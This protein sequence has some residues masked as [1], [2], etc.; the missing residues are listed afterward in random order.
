M[1][2]VN[3]FLCL[4]YM[5]SAI[6]L[7][8]KSLKI[9]V[10]I[11]YIHFNFPLYNFCLLACSLSVPWGGH[12][13][14]PFCL[15]WHISAFFVFRQPWATIVCSSKPQHL[16][17]STIITFLNDK[18]NALHFTKKISQFHR[19]KLFWVEWDEKNHTSKVI[20]N[21]RKIKVMWLM[22]AERQKLKC[23]MVD[24]TF[25]AHGRLLSPLAR[26]LKKKLFSWVCF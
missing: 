2:S 20:I 15:P 9:D 4:C 12:E 25:G 5:K 17:L 16:S 13:P 8:C 3:Y 22:A 19:D 11:L 14:Q 18:F 23:E 6:H 24:Q 1:N 10:Y 7:A 26:Y 21:C